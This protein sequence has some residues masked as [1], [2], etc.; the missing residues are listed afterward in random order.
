MDDLEAARFRIYALQDGAVRSQTLSFLLRSGFFEVLANGP[1][2]YEVLRVRAGLS[3]RVLPTI[4]AFTT[5]NGL[6]ELAPGG[7]YQLTAPARTF[8]LR[9]SPRYVG[10]RALL[11]EGFFE[12][13]GHL[14]EALRSGNPWTEAG[15]HDMFARFS[16]E[17]RRTFAEGMFANA[18]HGARILMEQVDLGPRRRLLD[19]GGGGGGYAIP[20]A[21]AFPHISVTIFDLPEVRTLAED[22]IRLAGLEER[23]AFVPGSFF[24]DPLPRGH[25]VVLLSSILHD[26]DEADCARILARCHAAIEPGGT[27]IITEPMLAE[28]FSGPDHPAASGLTMALLGGRNR[29]RSEVAALLEA[30]GFENH[31]QSELLPQNSVVTASRSRVVRWPHSQ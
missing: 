3:G 20:I 19:L 23:I 5:S 31:W 18:A 17:E 2:P 4:L 12:A 13:I 25:D 22:R 21:E 24:D 6:T 30:A 16:E 15:Q 28:D 14:P 7:G 8:L 26:W 29:T 9:E 10:G 1:M 27:V 11:F